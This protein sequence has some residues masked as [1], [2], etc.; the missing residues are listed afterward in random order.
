MYSNF[1]WLRLSYSGSYLEIATFRSLCPK[2][3]ISICVRKV[4]CIQTHLSH[5]TI[6]RY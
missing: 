3:Y 5:L 2:G 6:T 4:P 1:A